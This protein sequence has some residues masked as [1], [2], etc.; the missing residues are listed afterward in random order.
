M[1]ISRRVSL[2]G[3]LKKILEEYVTEVNASTVLSAESKKKMIDLGKLIM[4]G[5]FESIKEAQ[6]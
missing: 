5:L 6:G 2:L 1:D 3:E 4:N